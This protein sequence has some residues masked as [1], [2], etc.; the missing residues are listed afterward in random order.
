MHYVVLYAQNGDRIVTVDSVTSL[1]HMYITTDRL[2][3]LDR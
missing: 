2:L 3:Y 1:H